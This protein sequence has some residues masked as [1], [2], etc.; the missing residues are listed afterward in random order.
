MTTEPTRLT[1]PPGLALRP[2]TDDDVP[3]LA[4]LYASTRREEVAQLPWSDE[5][6]EAF[7]RWQF[8]NQR[9]H[10][11]QYYPECQFLVVERVA[12][13]GGGAEPVGRLYV[14]RWPSEVRLVDIALLPAH[15]G[16]GIGGALLCE[17][18]AEGDARGLPVTIH[19]E[20][21]NPALRL[22]RR[23]GFRHV[24][25]NGI[26]YLMRWEPGSSGPV[27]AAEAPEDPPA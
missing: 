2:E 8:N 15:R 10:Y 5:E 25:S 21:S 14:D 9:A 16:A 7:L 27:P 17:L 1:A 18:L 6:K 19:V 12:D 26:Y 4:E 11:R 23:L 3:F 24:D 22:Y 20:Y 13:D